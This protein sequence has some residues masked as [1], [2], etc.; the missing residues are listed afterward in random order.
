VTRDR[1]L[2]HTGRLGVLLLPAAAYLVWAAYVRPFEEVSPVGGAVGVLLGLFI[3]SRPAA[4]GI[5]LMFLERGALGRAVA[6]WNGVGWLALNLLVLLVGWLVLV[7][8]TTQFTTR[9][10]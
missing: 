3:C 9:P 7:V 4:N 10:N 1:L 5:E 2:P 8:G 6:R